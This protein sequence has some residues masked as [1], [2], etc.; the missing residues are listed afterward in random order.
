MSAHNIAKQVSDSTKLAQ[1]LTAAK[2]LSRDDSWKTL[3]LTLAGGFTVTLPL[4]Y[5]GLRF[6]FIVATAP[7]TAYIIKT[8]ATANIMYGMTEERAGTAGVAG[9]AKN[10]FNFV[11][12]V[13]I[14]G[15]W[16]EFY[17]DGT[18]WYY[19]GMVDVAAGNTVA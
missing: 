6:R 11:A 12:N 16:V 15:D 4:P 9:A 14:I 2:T 1:V 19:H 13:A 10:T 17:S 18:N 8:N 7:T 5:L 3:Y